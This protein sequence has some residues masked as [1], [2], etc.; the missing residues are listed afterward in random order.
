MHHTLNNRFALIAQL[1]RASVFGVSQVTLEKQVTDEQKRV[2]TRENAP[3]HA[4]SVNE[5]SIEGVG[6]PS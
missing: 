2:L 1:D 3:S 4:L 5:L 6:E